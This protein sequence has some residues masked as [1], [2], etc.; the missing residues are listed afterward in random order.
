MT[1]YVDGFVVPVPRNKLDAYRRAAEQPGKIWMEK[2]T[3]TYWECL[4]DD[5]KPGKVTSFP[6]SVQLKPDEVVAFSWILYKSRED[7]DR[8]NAEVMEDPRMKDMMDPK[9]MPFDG[10][11]MFWGGFKSFVELGSAPAAAH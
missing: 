11:R 8:V 7:R 1:N 9:K 5:V 4:G 10:M 2:G 3:L 6:Q